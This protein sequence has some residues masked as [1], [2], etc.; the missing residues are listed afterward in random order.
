MG[1]PAEGG[2]ENCDLPILMAE[3][4]ADGSERT[5]DGSARCL[6]CCSYLFGCSTTRREREN[7]EFL[8]SCNIAL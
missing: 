6:C 1:G 3:V 4:V 8:V 2:K 7:F 5:S